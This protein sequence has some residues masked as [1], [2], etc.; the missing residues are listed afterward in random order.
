MRGPLLS[1]LNSTENTAIALLEELVNINSHTANAGGVSNVQSR[2]EA[3]LRRLGMQI[4]R[5]SRDGYGDLLIARTA[6]ASAQQPVLLLGHAD[7]VY[8]TSSEQDR[9][10]RDGDIAR[11]PGVMDMKGGLATMIWALQALHSAALLDT[12]PVVVL[13]NCDEET[14]SHAF[15]AK[16]EAEARAAHAVLVFEPGRPQD[17]IVTRRKGLGS[18]TISATGK[19]SHAGNAHQEGQNAIT[20]L[21]RSILKIE[22][23]TNY[24]RGITLSVGMVSGGS[25][26][27]TVPEIAAAQFDVRATTAADYEEIRGALQQLA[28]IDP[29]TGAH[30]SLIE[31]HYWPPMEESP[32]SEALYESYRSHATAAGLSYGKFPTIVGG[33]SDGNITS[34]VGA[35]TIDGLGPYGEHPHSKDERVYLSSLKPKAANLALFLAGTL[36]HSSS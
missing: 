16:I 20:A 24:A 2:I 26:V 19:A 6:L 34:G 27:N 33:G 21:A 35:P 1:F 13:I 12:I 32:A 11:G 23:L 9:F 5:H 7:T 22:A 30:I 31:Y 10:V 14:G 36:N 17:A 3:E 25:A 18:W 4:E 15:R 29:V 28:G 8:P